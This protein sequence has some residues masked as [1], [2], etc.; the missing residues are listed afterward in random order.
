VLTFRLL[1]VMKNWSPFTKAAP[2][3]LA[4]IFFV[5]SGTVGSQTT[6]PASSSESVQQTPDLEGKNVVEVRILSD[7]GE[8]IKEN[9][10]DLPLSAGKPYDS[11]AERTSLRKLF[12]YGDFADLRTEVTDVQGGLRVDFVARRNLFIG[13]VRVEGLVEPPNESSAMAAMR[14]GVGTPFHESEL[15]DALARL[16]DALEQDGLYQAQIH[17][18]RTADLETKRMNIT[19]RVT[20]GPRARLGTITLKNP[21]SFANQELLSRAKLK[22][23]TQINAKKL[24][25]AG[26]LLRTFLTKKDFLGARAT[27]RRGVYDPQTNL[28]PLDLDVV[29]GSRVKVEVTGAKIP[30]KELRKLVPVYEEGAVDQD[31]LLEG[32]RSLRDYFERQGYFEAEVEYKAGEAQPVGKK[33]SGATEQVITYNVNHGPK[34]RLV[35]LD[36]EGEHYFDSG[37]LRSRMNIKPAAFDSPGKFSQRLLEDDVAGLQGLYAAN[38]FLDINMTS[39]IEHAHGGKENDLFVHIHVREGAQTLV[40]K[41]TVEGNKALGLKELLNVIGSSAGEPYSDFNVAIDRD[42]ILAFYYNEG[43]PDARFTSTLEKI[44]GAE[45]GADPAGARN[46]RVA[47]KYQ[48]EEGEQIRVSE[49]QIG[50]YEHTRRGVIAREIQVKPGEP[51]RVGEVLDTQR[52]LYNLGIFSR[53]TLEPQNPDGTDPEKALDVIVEEAKRYTFSYGGGIEIQRLGGAG[54]PAGDTGALEASPR[55]ILELSKANLTGR[56]DTLSFKVRASLL[57]GRGLVSYNVPDIFGKPSLSFQA[58]IF[59]DRSRDVTTFTSTRYEGSLQI[60]ER[61]SR[62]TTMVYS[63]TYRKVLIDKGTLEISPEEIPLFSQPTQVSEVGVSWLRE[64]RDNPTDATRGTFN[65]VDFS[66]AGK[67]IGSSAGFVR[68]FAQ[69]SSF[70]PLWRGMV[71]ARSTRFGIQQTLPGTVS[72][73]IPLPERFFAGGGTSLRGFGLNEAGP[74][75][76]LTGF[77]VGGQAMLVFNQELRFPM[78]LP[79]VGSK[80]GGALFYDAGNVFSRVGLITFRTRPSPI[81]QTAGDLAYFSHTIGFGLRYNTP[82][83][84]VRVDLAYQL[85]PPQYFTSCVIGTLGCGANGTQ[86]AQ[87][88]HFQFFFNLGDIF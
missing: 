14:L 20:S 87:L 38:G 18:E 30:D 26:D 23:G 2:A 32:Q 40:E 11:D 52:R 3:F 62:T 49:V 70:H 85:N 19:V 83:G 46:P 75:D 17:V 29:A 82:I 7:T 58:T 48:I 84:P 77:P 55:V 6:A 47:L 57:Q 76:P 35:G 81:S 42:N 41:L 88:P 33:D 79:K 34:Q 28:L 12:A 86:L 61:V 72:D 50:G 74:R 15:T 25:R 27:V 5:T 78:R 24:Q 71:F 36:F 63:Y 44:P 4:V 54:T 64:H 59:G 69:N 21:T 16:K 73:E 60:S 56:A 37:V 65:S 43:F 39:E 51:L 31:L 13:V 1:S 45:G 80:L 66:L 10:A 8:L 67:S 22:R 53:V 9:P 68:V